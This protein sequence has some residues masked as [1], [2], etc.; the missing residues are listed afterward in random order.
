MEDVEMSNS[1]TCLWHEG[2]Y[3]MGSGK[4]LIHPAFTLLTLCLNG[5]PVHVSSPSQCTNPPFTLTP[6]SKDNR[7]QFNRQN[8]FFGQ[9][10][11]AN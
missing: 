11:E 7:R 8:I 3:Y 4:H 9:K 10:T 6:P 5:V 2:C 1:H